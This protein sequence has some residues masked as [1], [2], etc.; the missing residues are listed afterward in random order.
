MSNA[1]Q[2]PLLIFADEVFGETYFVTVTR[3]NNGYMATIGDDWWIAYGDTVQSAIDRVVKNYEQ[4]M[5]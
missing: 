2:P 3:T 1:F 4:E 5:K